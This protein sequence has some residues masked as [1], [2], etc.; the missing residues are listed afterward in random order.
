MPRLNAV[1]KL[2]K[3]YELFTKGD[4]RKLNSGE[5]D[6]L[7]GY[8]KGLTPAGQT[9]VKTKLVEIFR[10]AKYDRGQR[11]RFMQDLLGVGFTLTDLEGTAGDTAASFLKLSKSAQFEKLQ[12]LFGAGGMVG[13]GFT[14]EINAAD[15]ARDAKARI[16]TKMDTIGE[17]LQRKYH[18]EAELGDPTWSAVY[19]EQGSAGRGQELLGYVLELP[20]YAE[21]HDVDRRYF[22]N[23]KGDLL[24]DVYCGE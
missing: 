1:D 16:T 6:A 14:K 17:Q 23:L 10:E 20:I 22:F 4:D 19:R 24:G 8:Y 3:M 18:N 2:N 15:V 5:T 9:K 11:D 12:A 21:D 7:V 13:D